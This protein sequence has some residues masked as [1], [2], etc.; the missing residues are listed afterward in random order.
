MSTESSWIGRTYH[1]L[2]QSY[3]SKQSSSKPTLSTTGYCIPTP[4]VLWK[5]EV[6]NL[7]WRMTALTWLWLYG[8]YGSI[9]VISESVRSPDR[10]AAGCNTAAATAAAAA[11]CGHALSIKSFDFAI[12]CVR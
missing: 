3:H 2:Y 7:L 5:R 9:L 6:Y 8:Q 10:S 11:A 4:Q 1:E 12:S